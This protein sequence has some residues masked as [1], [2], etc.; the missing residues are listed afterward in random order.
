MTA[1]GRPRLGGP[2]MAPPDLLLAGLF[3]ER[4]WSASNEKLHISPGS[5]TASSVVGRGQ[6]NPWA[7]LRG[8][9]TGSILP[10]MNNLLLEKP[11]TVGR[12]D[13][14]LCKAFEML[15]PKFFWVRANVPG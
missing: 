13:Q 9:F 8:S 6:L 7:Y 4:P 11:K 5:I 15:L 14:I 2:F 10:P 1:V 3:R 12:Y